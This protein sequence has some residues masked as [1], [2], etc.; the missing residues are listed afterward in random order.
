[1]ASQDDYTNT[2]VTSGKMYSSA[3][4]RKSINYHDEP[5][6]LYIPLVLVVTIL[7]V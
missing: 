6:L 1:M 3:T 4:I 2:S 7:D 5:L